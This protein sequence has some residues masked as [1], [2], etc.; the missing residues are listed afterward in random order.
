M[1]HHAWL[2]LALLACGRIDEDPQPDAAVT[3]TTESSAITTT[4]VIDSGPLVGYSTGDLVVFKGIPYVAPPLGALRFAPPAPAPTWTWPR[5]AIFNPPMCPQS[6][7]SGPVGS[8]DCLTINVWT[9]PDAVHRPV[10]FFVH[11]GAGISGSHY[12]SAALA[13]ATGAVVVTVQYRLGTLGH[14][15]LPELDATGGGNFALLDQQAALRWVQRNIAAFGGDATHVLLFG[16]SAGGF[17]TCTHTI[18]PESRGLFASA[19][20]ESGQCTDLPD[21]ATQYAKWQADVV[22][23]VGCNSGD[24]IACLRAVTPAQLVTGLKQS[25]SGPVVDGSH[26][27]LHAIDAWRTG[28]FAHVPLVVGTNNDEANL[29]LLLYAVNYWWLDGYVNSQAGYTTVVQILFPA[30]ASLL[31]AMYPYASY[32]SGFA[33]LDAMLTDIGLSCPVR[34]W[35]R[36]VAA[37][38]GTVWQFEFTDSLAGGYSFLGTP[39]ALELVW[40]FSL[41]SWI[42]GYV[43]TAAQLDLS[44]YMQ[45]VWLD[46]AGSGSVPDDWPLAGASESHYELGPARGARTT[47]RGGRCDA[48]VGAGLVTPS[49]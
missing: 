10:L 16:E 23:T 13:R 14:L 15:A 48:L 25:L 34:G 24:R 8:E 31:L 46:L 20:S 18:A 39:H 42:P 47:F 27:P 41:W 9:H 43:P 4:V 49:M 35:A 45:G 19:L 33:A 17:Y 32:G 44:A 28:A 37:G 21:R 29:W 30:Q 5:W 22:T 3:T 1:K 12:D 2:A 6:S 26:V 11:G 7:S 40:V 36:A 38:G